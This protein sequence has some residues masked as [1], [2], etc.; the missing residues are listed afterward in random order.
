MFQKSPEI[1]GWDSKIQLDVQSSLVSVQYREDLMPTYFKSKRFGLL[2]VPRLI[3][4]MKEKNPIIHP[5]SNTVTE[6][7]LNLYK[8]FLSKIWLLS[9][10]GSFLKW[11]APGYTAPLHYLNIQVA[12]RRQHYQTMFTAQRH[13]AFRVNENVKGDQESLHIFC[14]PCTTQPYLRVTKNTRQWTNYSEN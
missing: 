11:S 4:G 13:S 1:L 9:F 2:T 14:L 8:Y 3:I 10:N 5:L 12:S 7:M 6:I